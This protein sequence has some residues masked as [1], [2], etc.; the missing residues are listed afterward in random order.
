MKKSQSERLQTLWFQLS[1]ISKKPK[2]METER[3]K[4]MGRGG[5]AEHW[6]FYVSETTLY[7]IIKVIYVILHLSK[8]TNV[9]HLISTKIYYGLEVIII[10]QCKFILGNKYD[11][12]VNDTDNGKAMRVWGEGICEFSVLFNFVVNL[13]LI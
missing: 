1:H 13:K 8:P 10:Y 9:Q 11:I 4:V 12:L 7:E 5:Y 6:R 2:T 3:G